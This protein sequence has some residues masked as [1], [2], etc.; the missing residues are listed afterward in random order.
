MAAQP[1]KKKKEGKKDL[2]LYGNAND[3]A[4]KN[5]LGPQI[6]RMPSHT[7]TKLLR[8]RTNPPSRN[9][10]IFGLERYQKQRTSKGF[11]TGAEDYTSFLIREKSR[12]KAIKSQ[13]A[14]FWGFPTVF[15]WI[16]I[17]TVTVEDAKK[18][19]AF[20]YVLGFLI[21]SGYRACQLH[22]PFHKCGNIGHLTRECQHNAPPQ[23][24]R[25]TPTPIHMLQQ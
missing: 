6:A 12:F 23:K 11:Q 8:S 20:F 25:P 18:V 22:R 14:T 9:F 19:P 17:T 4:R 24:R 7:H 10:A 15:T 5:H 3:G 16:S 2:F 21:M 1:Q 13:M